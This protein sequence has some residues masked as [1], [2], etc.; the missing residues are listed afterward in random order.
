VLGRRA[1]WSEGEQLLLDELCGGYAQAWELAR[2]E[3]APVRPG[4][5]RRLRRFALWAGVIALHGIALVP[6]RSSSI[7][8]AEVIASAPAFVRAPFAGVVDS[9]A[10]SPNSE[11]K[12]GQLLV[13]LERR[14]LEAEYG[15]AVKSMEVATV[16][17]RQVSQEAMTDLRAREQLAVYRG[18]LEEARADYE[19]RRARLERADIPSPADGIA[20]FN[21]AGDWIGRPIELGERIM[22][23]S[24]PTSS[25]IEIDLPVSEATTFDE[26]SEVSFFSNLNPDQSV[27]GRLVFMS[28]ATT[29]TPSGVLI[30][31]ARAELKEGS[32]L[33]LGV[34]GT[35]KIYGP[36]R[37]LIVWLLRRPLAF[38]RQWI[39]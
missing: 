4:R 14:Q 17:Y 36:R 6:V 28:Y 12:A 38:V 20:V 26:G 37:P 30:Y 34:K 3:R 5:A 11:V 9:I 16:Q 8:P 21:D 33:R 31:T 29:L 24:P 19:Y 2:T 18:K 35:A 10:V 7:A 13:R 23:V 1:P 25:R 22:L 27:S 32:A 39:G 15:V